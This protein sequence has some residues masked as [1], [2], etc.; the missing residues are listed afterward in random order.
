MAAKA[1]TVIVIA[2]PKIVVGTATSAKSLTRV[3][4]KPLVILESHEKYSRSSA[5]VWLTTA[6]TD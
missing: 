2:E 5:I 1:T 6:S 3:D 4:F